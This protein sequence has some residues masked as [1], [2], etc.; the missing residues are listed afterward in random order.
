[1][2]KNGTGGKKAKSK[3]NKKEKKKLQEQEEMEQNL[4]APHMEKDN[5]GTIVCKITKVFGYGRY[6]LEMID[7]EKSYIGISRH[8][9]MASKLKLNNIVLASYRECNTIQ[10]EIDILFVY[11]EKQ[12]QNLLE[13]GYIK[14]I[15]YDNYE[16]DVFDDIMTEEEFNAI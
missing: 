6:L 10:R 7:N 4:I 16:L 3:S 2:V 11:S 8:V 5:K 12:V 1:M 15:D 14:R 9:K 13:Y